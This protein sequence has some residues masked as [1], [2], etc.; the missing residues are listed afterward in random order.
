MCLNENG[1]MEIVPR[2]TDGSVT[3]PTGALPAGGCDGVIVE[4]KGETIVCTPLT[5]DALARGMAK[6]LRG[7]ERDKI[8]KE[9]E[10]AGRGAGT[11]DHRD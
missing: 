3:L 2:N 11:N 7:V 9:A 6:E 1:G 4:R 10:H 5:G 8:V